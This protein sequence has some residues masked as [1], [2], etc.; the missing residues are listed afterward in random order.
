MMEEDGWTP[1]AGAST[2]TALVM[3]AEL[4][5]TLRSEPWKSAVALSIGACLGLVIVSLLCGCQCCGHRV[6]VLWRCC[7]AVR[8]SRVREAPLLT[9]APRSQSRH[10]VTPQAPWLG[11]STG[12]PAAPPRQWWERPDVR[13]PEDAA[14]ARVWNSCRDL[15]GPDVSDATIAQLL[16]QHDDDVEAAA[17]AFFGTPRSLGCGGRADGGIGAS[18]V[19]GSGTPRPNVGACSPVFAATRPRASGVAALGR[20]VGRPP[21]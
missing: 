6:Q 17:T 5:E 14:D 7:Y 13:R 1:A 9:T 4:R 10:W 3:P 20:P 16:Q 15:V 21:R 18:R 11:V 2:V 19:T 8:C 12:S